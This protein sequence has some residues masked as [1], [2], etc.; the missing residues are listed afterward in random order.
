[1][2]ANVATSESTELKRQLHTGLGVIHTNSPVTPIVP[3]NWSDQVDGAVFQFG[4]GATVRTDP[5][6]GVSATSE[7]VQF[8]PGVSTAVRIDPGNYNDNAATVQ[9]GPTTVASGD[10]AVPYDIGLASITQ[11]GARIAPAD[12]NHE[13]TPEVGPNTL[14]GLGSTLSIPSTMPMTWWTVRVKVLRPTSA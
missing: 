7:S 14:R 11:V 6:I 12:Y 3:H 2:R 10:G 13:E 9:I 8:H 4:Q 5:A 1:M